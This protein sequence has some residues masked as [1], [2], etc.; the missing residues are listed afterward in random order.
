MS[1]NNIKQTSRKSR[2]LILYWL[3]RLI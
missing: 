1:K 3:N 2:L